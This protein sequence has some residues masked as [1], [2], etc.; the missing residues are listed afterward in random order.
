M[1][2][3]ANGLAKKDS[4]RSSWS[5][6][7]LRTLHILL[8]P[9]S[10]RGEELAHAS[11]LPGGYRRDIEAKLPGQCLLRE[12]L[13]LPRSPDALRKCLRFGTR[14]VAKER[15]HLGQQAGRNL[16]VVALPVADRHD[17]DAKL[18][19]HLLLQEL[20]VHADLPEVLAEGLGVDR[21]STRLNSSHSQISYAVFCLK[22]KKTRQ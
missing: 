9:S 4:R 18:R 20:A 13:P 10:H 1:A 8:E 16:R 21:K 6:Y 5:R 17:R 12:A 15:H 14:I 2:S 7:F 11:T 19:C 3:R 22:K